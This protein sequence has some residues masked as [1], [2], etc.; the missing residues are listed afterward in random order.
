MT[1]FSFEKSFSKKYVDYVCFENQQILIL[2]SNNLWLGN[3]HPD[4]F[5]LK[6]YLL[7]LAFR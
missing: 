2:N 4:H 1:S 6:H 5:N 7:V 3:V